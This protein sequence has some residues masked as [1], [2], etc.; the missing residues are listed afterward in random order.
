MNAEEIMLKLSERFYRLKGLPISCVYSGRL[1]AAVG[2]FEHIPPALF[3][4]Y[5]L[6]CER[7]P[8]AFSP[9]THCKSSDCAMGL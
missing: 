7:L 4:R 1:T 6:L 5:S 8:L 3:S 2:S 9:R